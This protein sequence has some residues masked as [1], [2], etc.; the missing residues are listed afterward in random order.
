M[1]VAVSNQQKRHWVAKILAIWMF[2]YAANAVLLRFLMLSGVLFLGR[3]GSAVGAAGPLWHGWRVWALAIEQLVLDIL[4]LLPTPDLL[5]ALRAFVISTFHL[6]NRAIY[7][8]ESILITASLVALAV[9]M[10]FGLLRGHEW[11]R[12]SYAVLCLLGLVLHS[13]HSLSLFGLL[14]LLV[15]LIAPILLLIFLIWRGLFVTTR[16]QAAT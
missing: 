10:G 3:Q 12:W 11:A 15:Q 16:T 6:T 7:L 5:P 13:N 9:A 4:H 8:R 1:P 2:V 14:G